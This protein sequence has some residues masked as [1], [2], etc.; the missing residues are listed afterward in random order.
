MD[1]IDQPIEYRAPRNVASEARLAASRSAR[2]IG[3]M[4][5]ILGLGAILLFGLIHRDHRLKDLINPFVLAFTLCALGNLT[6]GILYLIASVKILLPDPFWERLVTACVIFNLAAPAML[7]IVSASE[8]ISMMTWAA[9]VLLPVIL[10]QVKLMRR[11]RA[12]RFEP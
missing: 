2:G 1:L 9:G 3:V 5:L 7:I 12:L 10:W 4:C 8:F 11:T 6:G